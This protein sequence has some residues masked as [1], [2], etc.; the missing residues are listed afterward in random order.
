MVEPKEPID[1]LA[2]AS[3]RAHEICARHFLFLEGSCKELI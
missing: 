3:E 2:M 1:L